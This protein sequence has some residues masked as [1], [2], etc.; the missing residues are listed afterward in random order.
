MHIKFNCKKYGTSY[1]F[2]IKELPT[3]AQLDKIKKEVQERLKIEE[4]K[5]D[6]GMPWLEACDICAEV[7]AKYVPIGHNT[8]IA[9]IEIN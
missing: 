7:L 6:N 3:N 1:Q 5:Y 2:D 9:T 4:E 8:H